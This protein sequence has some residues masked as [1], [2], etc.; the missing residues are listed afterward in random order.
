MADEQFKRNVAHKLRINDI[1]IG[2]PVFDQEKFSFL[3][4]GNKRIIRINLVA[5][6]I[7]RYE[8]EGEKKYSF[9][10]IDDGSGQIKLKAFGDDINKFKNSLQGQT[11][12][13]I[14]L[15]RHWNNETYIS[16]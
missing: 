9:F 5:N 4:L 6:I 1:L 8:S 14:G 13:I 12:L 7:E 11:V 10:T 2:K 16:P 3:E 15:L